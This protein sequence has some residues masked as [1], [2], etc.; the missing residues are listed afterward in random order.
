[1]LT[2]PLRLLILGTLCGLALAFVMVPWPPSKVSA[3]SFEP[4]T[5]TFNL[6]ASASAQIIPNCTTG[7]TGCIPG[8][9]QVAHSVT[10]TMSTAAACGFLLDASADNSTFNTIAANSTGGVEGYG[11]IFTVTAQANG[12][13]P[14]LRIKVLPCT[15]SVTVTYTGY[16]SPQPI[17]FTGFASHFAVTSYG[18][19]S[20][21]GHLTPTV[22][23]GLQ[24]GNTDTSAV[25]YLWVAANL[26]TRVPASDV[27]LLQIPIGPSATW[28]YSGPPINVLG[29]T[30]NTA[31]NWLYFQGTTTASGGTN[32]TNPIL[33]NLQTTGSGPYYP[34]FPLSYP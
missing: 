10:L 21:L 19:V 30:Q 1:M 23:L 22:I 2:R 15:S 24:C 20:L 25:A 8:F 16:N 12:Y 31:L 5:K 26:A 27:V 28:D 6:P 4:F 7:S 29:V 14:Y 9:K 13:Y 11:T 17:N 3:Q 33:C 18:S 32:V 34:F